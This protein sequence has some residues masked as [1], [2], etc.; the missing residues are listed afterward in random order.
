MVDNGLGELTEVATGFYSS[1]A[2]YVIPCYE[3]GYLDCDLSKF[4]EPGCCIGDD[5]MEGED[6]SGR[7]GAICPSDPWPCRFEPS[8]CRSIGCLECDEVNGE[9]IYDTREVLHSIDCLSYGTKMWPT[10]NEPSRL[11][12]TAGVEYNWAIACGPS[13]WENLDDGSVGRGEY[14]CFAYRSVPSGTTSPFNVTKSLWV[15]C[16]YIQMM[17]CGCGVLNP[18]TIPG[19]RGPK[20]PKVGWEPCITTDDCPF[21]CHDAGTD[22]A[23]NLCHAFSEQTD[24]GI[25]W[26][27]GS[28]YY[29]FD[30]F[31]K[32]GN[33]N[34]LNT[35]IIIFDVGE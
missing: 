34:E 31:A 8:D 2:C 24:N 33:Y 7:C 12:V 3:S 10:I 27:E 16:Q 20:D 1:K 30:V 17:E 5:C 29:G 23:R 14:A 35:D 32:N 6:D 18:D 15:P 28:N 13:E 4:Y 25:D 9:R 26:W 22:N 11:G 21:L 19:N